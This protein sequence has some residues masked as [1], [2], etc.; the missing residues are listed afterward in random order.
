[1]ASSAAA[2]VA[3]LAAAAAISATS[4]NSGPSSVI[5]ASQRSLKAAAASVCLRKTKVDAYAG[6]RDRAAARRA[7]LQCYTCRAGGKRN[8]LPPCGKGK[9][10]DGHHVPYSCTLLASAN[11]S[12]P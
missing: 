5:R 4:A 6:P 12:Q 1:M 11:S 9:L 8:C 3:P 10:R 2:T 7:G